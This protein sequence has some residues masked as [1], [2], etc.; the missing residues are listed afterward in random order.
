MDQ[1]KYTLTWHTYSGH[2]RE[3]LQKMKK[4]NYL[5]D[6]TLV[7]EDKKLVK[8]H[9]IVLS[10]CSTVFK[11]IVDSISDNDS[12]IY[13]KGI[14]NLEVESLLEFMYLGEVTLHQSRIKEFLDAAKSLDVKE[15][16]KAVEMQEIYAEVSEENITY[17]N[18]S[19]V[20]EQATNDKSIQENAL[21]KNKCYQCEYQTSNSSY[22]KIHIQS[23]HVGMKMDCSFCL[24]KFADK[25]NLK[26]HIQSKHEGIKFPCNNCQLQFS[27]KSNL[28]RH[29]DAEHKEIRY[30]C[31]LC[32]YQGKSQQQLNQHYETAHEGVRYPCEHCDEK[33]TTKGYV[34]FHIESVHENIKRFNCGKCDMQYSTKQHLKIH[35]QNM[36]EEVKFSCELC[37]NMYT[38]ESS[39]RRHLKSA[40]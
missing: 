7:S 9:K 29:F 23:V 17:S 20:E 34:K 31:K 16:S 35:L 28:K 26:K 38:L 33:F 2:L 10:A 15:I 13:L 39:L 19:S 1:E 12:V 30:N 25:S 18:Y 21:K 3:M 5:T 11:D 6:V 4:E 37:N 32:H 27:K 40:H 14:Q 22:L 8:A 24:R 36:H